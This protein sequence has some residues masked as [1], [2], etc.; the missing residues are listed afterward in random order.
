MPNQK[1]IYCFNLCIEKNKAEKPKGYTFKN[2]SF[3]KVVSLLRSC[4]EIT[5]LQSIEGIP[6]IGKG[7]KE[8]IKE[9]LET[10]TMKEIKDY[11]I[12]TNQTSNEKTQLSEANAIQDLKRISGIGNVKASQLFKKGYTLDKLLTMFSQGED[13]TT[14]LTHHQVLGVKHFHDTELRIPYCEIQQFETILNDFQIFKNNDAFFK[15][16][17]SYRRK[18]ETSGDID[19]LLYRKNKSKDS[20]FLTKVCEILETYGI[21]IDHLTDYS[22]KDV[23]KYMGYCKIFNFPVRRLDIRCID[24]DCVAPATLYFTGSGE[25][26]RSMRIYSQKKGYKLNEYGLWKQ[27]E[28]IQNL[29]TEEDIFTFLDLPYVEPRDRLPNYVFK[30]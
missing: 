25:F 21:L 12:Q 20:T 19:V 29:N 4:D 22:K 27:E 3:E 16:C 13:L 10:G 11:Q 6:G 5:S 1:L 26:N 30:N 9:F 23:T 28:K 7:C 24:W 18:K 15:I 2:R 8:R 14:L 17:G